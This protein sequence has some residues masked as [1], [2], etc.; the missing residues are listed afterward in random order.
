MGD[1]SLGKSWSSLFIEMVDS[2]WLNNRVVDSRRGKFCFTRRESDLRVP[3]TRF[4]N[5][6]S[7]AMIFGW[8]NRWTAAAAAASAI[9]DGAGT[10]VSE[11]HDL[12]LLDVLD[13]LDILSEPP[14]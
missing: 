14:T 2:A 3:L 10:C 13:R 7:F 8:S 5:F 6:F 1:S 9:A 4:S 11:E 12:S